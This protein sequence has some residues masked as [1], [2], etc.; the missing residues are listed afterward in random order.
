[1]QQ[2]KN[3]E[4]KKPTRQSQQQDSYNIESSQPT[5]GLKAAY[6]KVNKNIESS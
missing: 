2:F 5:L 4:L 1:M 3:I 6:E